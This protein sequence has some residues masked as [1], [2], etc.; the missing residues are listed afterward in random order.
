[1]IGIGEVPVERVRDGALRNAAD[2]H[3]GQVRRLLRVDDDAL[4]DRDVGGEDHRARGH[5]GVA[6]SRHLR[7]APRRPVLRARG[8]IDLASEAFDLVDEPGQILERM[9]RGLAAR[10]GCTARCRTRRAAPGPRAR[11]PRC[12]RDAPPRGRDRGPPASLPREGRGR[13]AAARNR[14]RCGP[15]ST[16]RS[17][18]SIASAWLLAASRIASRPCMR[19]ISEKRSSITHERWAVVRDVIPLPIAPSSRTATD[20]P[21]FASW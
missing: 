19:S 20:A 3:V 15:P 18:A 17:I 1:M 16:V 11:R 2:D 14:S 5:G 7:G 4:V 8:G 12:P 13:P 21:L 6:R 10:T 9:E